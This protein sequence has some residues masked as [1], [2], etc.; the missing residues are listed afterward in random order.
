MVNPVPGHDSSAVNQS[1][2]PTESERQWKLSISRWI[3]NFDPT[4]IAKLIIGSPTDDDKGDGSV[5]A[6]AIYEDGK[7]VFVQ[8]GEATGGV[9][10]VIL[11]HG[12][13]SSGTLTIDPQAA[14][15]QK[16]TITGS[17]SIQPVSSKGGNCLLHVTNGS[18][19]NASFSGWVRPYPGP[20]INTT[21]GHKFAVTMYFFEGDGADYSVQPRQ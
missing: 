3:N 13:L 5:N 10:H 9:K 18:G 16:V 19:A 7:R 17:V 12:T 14:V 15:I 11:D 2:R 6:E 4:R 21:N 20:S 8:E 1:G